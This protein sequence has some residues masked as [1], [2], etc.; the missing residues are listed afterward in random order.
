LEVLQYVMGAGGDDPFRAWVVD[1]ARELI[2][3]LRESLVGSTQEETHKVAI[4]VTPSTTDDPWTAAAVEASCEAARGIVGSLTLERGPDVRLNLIVSPA[5][6]TAELMETLDLLAAPEGAFV[7]GSTF[8][9]RE[10][11]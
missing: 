1:G 9:L 7:A 10:G 5:D 6:R 8:D 3:A 4:V 11:R 2:A